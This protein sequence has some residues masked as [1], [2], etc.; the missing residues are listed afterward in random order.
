MSRSKSLQDDI[1]ITWDADRIRFESGHGEARWPWD[2]L[3]QWQESR[4]GLLLWTGSQIYHYLPKRVLTDDQISELRANLT[5][6]LGKPGKR[7]K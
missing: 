7:R 6:A 2:E 1:A 3:Y 5:R 4:G